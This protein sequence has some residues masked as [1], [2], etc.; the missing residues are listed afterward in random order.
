MGEFIVYP[1]IVPKYSSGSRATPE[2][3]FINNVNSQIQGIALANILC[4]LWHSMFVDILKSSNLE[5]FLY[6]ASGNTGDL[7]K[8]LYQ[9]LDTHR[10]FTVPKQV[11]LVL[12]T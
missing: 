2:I 12:G 6:H 10:K 1:Q 4:K 11:H 5:R 3:I 7:V 9:E 8:Q